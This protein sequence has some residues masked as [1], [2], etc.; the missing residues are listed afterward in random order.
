MHKGKQCESCLMPLD[1]KHGQMDR[2]NERYCNLCF[3]DGKLCYEGDDVKKFQRHA[4]EGM[5]NNGVGPLAARFFVFL[6]RF[7]PRWRNR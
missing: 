1:E 2:E 5:R 4:Y 6:I 7:A 3:R